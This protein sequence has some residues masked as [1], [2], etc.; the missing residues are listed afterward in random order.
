MTA[1]RWPKVPRRIEGLAGPIRVIVRRVE[2]FRAADGDTVWGL[3]R[4]AKREIHLA[5][6]IPP[7][8]RWHTLIHE[9]AHAWLIDAGLP[10]LLHGNGD[11]LD[12][13]IEVV[14]DTLAT[15]M[16][17]AMATTMGLDPLEKK[18]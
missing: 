14:C 7:A 11:E 10:N 4:P 1:Q 15:A 16:V 9:W 5:G 8:L 18:K 6:R 2:S 12:R 3:Y 17:R 13:N